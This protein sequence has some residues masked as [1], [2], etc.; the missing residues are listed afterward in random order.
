MAPVNDNSGH[1]AGQTDDRTAARGEDA[2]DRDTPGTPAKGNIGKSDLFGQG[3]SEDEILRAAVVD[4]GSLDTGDAPDTTGD[5]V[6]RP[7]RER[8]VPKLRLPRRSARARRSGAKEA[9]AAPSPASGEPD[10][11][12]AQPADTASPPD[13]ATRADFHEAPLPPVQAE[14]TS[15][16]HPAH[17][18]AAP[19]AGDAGATRAVGAEGEVV[20]FGMPRSRVAP[21]V[22]ARKV[23]VS[24]AL[25]VISTLI[26]ITLAVGI[27]LTLWFVLSYVINSIRA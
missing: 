6:V 17:T 10:A 23:A 13:T 22:V 2:A 20:V 9:A 11:Q 25:F 18:S 19:P 12:G 21:G 26:A 3:A 16:E 1:E 5:F 4:A 24:I 7:E 15:A 14:T 27:S 8:R